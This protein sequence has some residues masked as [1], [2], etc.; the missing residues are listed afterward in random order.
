MNL[1]I[2]TIT[3]KIKIKK[4][5]KKEKNA[6]N[7]NTNSIKENSS[8]KNDNFLDS[9]FDIAEIF[10]DDIKI[11]PFEETA[12]KQNN[13]ENINNI[14]LDIN[15]DTNKKN[16]PQLNNQKENS[17]QNIFDLDDVGISFFDDLKD[18]KNT[19]VKKAKP[20]PK[21]EQINTNSKENKKEKEKGKNFNLDLSNLTNEEL[22][23]EI[24]QRKDIPKFK[25]ELKKNN[26]NFEKIDASPEKS[27]TSSKKNYL[28]C[29]VCYNDTNDPELTIEIVLP[30][31]HFSCTKCLD[32]MKQ[33]EEIQ[34]CP[35]CRE[36]IN[37]RE[38]MYI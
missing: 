2:V 27:G 30:C 15:I 26:I 18:E 6:N 8:N 19:T 28:R 5:K 11:N 4:R 22:I 1:K 25:D 16:P 33:L 13:E 20:K 9:N 35:L 17:I 14:N 24:N 38:R 3:K 7:N 32:K 29:P 10:G 34:K 23:E 12:K 21:E 37:M 31:R 36:E